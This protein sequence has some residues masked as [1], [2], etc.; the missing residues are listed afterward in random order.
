MKY[1]AISLVL[2]L[3]ATAAGSAQRVSPAYRPFLSYAVQQPAGAAT[4]PSALDLV[5]GYRD[6]VAK[7]QNSTKVP[8]R[9]PTWVPYDDD[10]DN[11]VFASVASA[12]ASGYQVELAW[13]P[14]CGG[15]GA[16]HLGYIS[17][18]SSPL[19]ENKGPKIPVTLSG[20]IQGYF[21]D[22]GCGANCDDS[23]VYW[24]EGGNHYSIS[25]KA[26]IKETLVKM[27]NSALAT[28]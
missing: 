3:S 13:V 18:S 10:K 12:T 15:G 1:P 5:S 25:M 26:E 2:L 14:D 7:L 9:L 16:C 28:K 11:P 19:E 6:A 23:A 27:V 20:G 22:A 8:L 4:P 21:I 17:G 24:T